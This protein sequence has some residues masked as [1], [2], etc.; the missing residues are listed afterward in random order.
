MQTIQLQSIGL[1]QA[2]EAASLK[3]GDITVWNFGATEEIL[4]V[5]EPTAKFVKFIIRTVSNGST[6]ERRLKKTRLVGIKETAAEEEKIVMA[7]DVSSRYTNADYLSDIKAQT[8]AKNE[9]KIAAWLQENPRIG[10]LNSGKYYYHDVNREL[11]YINVFGVIP[12][13]LP[14]THIDNFLK[15]VTLLEAQEWDEEQD[16]FV[17]CLDY[18]GISADERNA[19]H[20]VERLEQKF[21]Q[22]LKGNG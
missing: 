18:F 16:K 8:L 7:S 15:R 4:E 11:Q 6:Y 9:E 3:V 12:E 20:W 2:V 14:A 17:F 13:E 22:L 5:L 19:D 1:V 21:K 10:S